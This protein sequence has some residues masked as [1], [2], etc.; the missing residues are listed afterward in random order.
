MTSTVL[1]ATFTPKT[2][3]VAGSLLASALVALI[4]LVVFFV[5]LGVLRLKAYVSALGALAAAL[6]VAVIAFNMPVPLALL[7][8]TQGAAFGLFPI[9][10]IVLTA[11]WL[12]ELTVIS[13]RMDDVRA[14]FSA[15]GS[16]D[17]RVQAMLIAFCFGALLE[18]LAGFGAPVAI[19]GAMLVAL[20]L[21][22]VRAAVTALVANTAPVAFG[23]MAIPITT[24]GGVTGIPPAEIAAVVGHQ[25]PL[26]AFIV[27]TL[28]LFLVDG[29]RGVREAWPVAAVTGV[30]FAILQ[31]WASNYF[32]YELT[33]V[34]ASLGSFAAAVVMLR[35]WRPTT[36][37]DQRSHV[38]ETA[39]G[40]TPRRVILGLLPYWLV[41]IIFG[42]GKLWRVGV[43][44]PAALAS[45]DVPIKW[46]GLYGHLIAADG[47]PATSAIYSFQWLS[48]PGTMLLIT[49]LIVTIVYATVG[50][51]DRAP[52]TVGQGIGAFFRTIRDMRFAILTI[53]TVLALAYV[54]NQSGQTVTIGTWMAA[55]GG[56]FAFFSPILGWLGTAVTG[57]DTSSNA[58][59]A[60]L[61]QTAGI[62]AGI[63][64]H[65]LVAAN[66]SGGVVG[67]MISP[68]NLTIAAAAIARPHSEP[69]LLRRGIGYSIALLLLLCVLVYLQSTPV[70]AGMLPY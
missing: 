19:T 25:T 2:D 60:K 20:G 3:P 22:P 7:S 37:D 53:A 28:L 13:G 44:L 46:P 42:V 27:P 43:D 38:V 61:Q 15:V 14:T 24:A 6:L 48:S 26:L 1:A 29:W 58:L 23:A 36:P 18:A 47:K 68:Q 69:E 63:N 30:V 12:Y 41:I 33:D 31:W 52:I 70:L 67:K 65:L 64:P 35:W 56:I 62:H 17:M 11:L 5:L 49:G 45:T 66:S 50:D 21:P 32:T 57:S 9:L 59:F 4:P 16:G 55:T 39:R 34:V 10:W 51:R 40:L 54:M 8:A